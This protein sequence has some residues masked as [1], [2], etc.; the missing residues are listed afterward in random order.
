M[1]ELVIA[2]NHLQQWRYN[3]TMNAG[4]P[5]TKLQQRNATMVRFDTTMLYLNLRSWNKPKFGRRTARSR[6]NEN[7]RA[8]KEVWKSSLCLQVKFWQANTTEEGGDERLKGCSAPRC[9][10]VFGRTS[11]PNKTKT[12]PPY[13]LH[14]IPYTTKWVKCGPQI[15]PPLL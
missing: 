10:P 6:I 3:P 1:D 11:F 8:V 4:L 9:D 7:V 14:I 12:F 5:T 2:Y 15:C 13:P